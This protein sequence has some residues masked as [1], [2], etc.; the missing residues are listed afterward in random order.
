MF[1]A[2]CIRTCACVGM[3][4]NNANAFLLLRCV[5]VRAWTPALENAPLNGSLWGMPVWGSG[6]AVGC[7]AS[8]QTQGVLRN[9]R[10]I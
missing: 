4:A 2:S 1:V 6:W 7:R 8:R 9:L 10:G 5:R 3:R